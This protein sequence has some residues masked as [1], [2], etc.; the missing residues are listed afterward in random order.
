MFYVVTARWNV[1]QSSRRRVA[2]IGAGGAGTTAAWLLDP[3]HDVTLYERSAQLGGH[4]HTVNAEVDGL[5]VPVDDG[6]AWFSDNLYPRMLRLLERVGASTRMVDMTWGFLDARRGR[7]LLLPPEG[8]TGLARLLGRT[9][10]LPDLF[11]LEGAIRAAEPLVREGRM[12]W[13]WAE[14]LARHRISRAFAADVLTPIVAGAWGAPY[15]RISD[16]SAYALLKYVVLHR[17]GTLTPFRWH[18]LRGG[19][20][21]YVERVASHM[22]R[23]VV[24]RS[25]T[26]DAAWRDEVGWLVRSGGEVA[27]FD[28]VVLA[29]GVGVA[30]RLLAGCA[31][32]DAVR[33]VLE[34]FEVYT[35]RVA[36]HSD[37]RLMP[38]HRS[39]WCVANL[40]YDGSESRMTVWAGHPWRLPVFTTPLGDAAPPSRTHHVSSFEL[41][42]LT[43]EHH[44]AQVALQ[45]VQGAAGLH[46][47]GDWTRDIGSHED[48]VTSAIQAAEA[49][50]PASPRLAEIRAPRSTPPGIAIGQA[51]AEVA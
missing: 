21:S 46:L 29:T 49:L 6:A 34:R 45:A 11:R 17:P 42:L 37:P 25:T 43:P 4:A 40:R 18:V 19:V 16:M 12:D 41:P 33:A 8:L 51:A 48:A 31:G 3:T 27:R 22:E 35:S 26:V 20:S 32:I 44:R 9:T 28:A 47:A 2:V 5:T 23:V 14:F 38:R 30:R 1:F 10:W 39:D 13:S 15:A 24:R 7:P 50:A 36:T